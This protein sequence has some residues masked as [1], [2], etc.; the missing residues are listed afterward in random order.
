MVRADDGPATTPERSD[1]DAVVVGGSLAGCATAIFLARAGARVAL[2]EK[3]PDPAA[4]K[5]VCGHFIQSSAVPT[6]ERLGLLPAIEAAGGVRSHYRI[7]TRWGWMPAPREERVPRSLNLRREKL[8][9]LIRA[10]AADTPGVELIA[11][12]T[13][14]DLLGG[15]GRVEG[16]EVSAREGERTRLR[17]PLVVGA[18]GRDSHV[19]RA[20]GVRVRET[21]H[22]RF[23]YGAYYEGPGP[24]GAPDASLWFTDPHWAAAFPT[25]DGLT[26][27][28]CMPTADRL[29]EFRRDP[30]AALEAFV[31]DLPGAPPIR[32]ARRVSPII[33]KVKMPNLQR[34][35]TAP[36]LALVGDAALATDPLWGVGC[37][38]AFQTA[39][40]LADSVAPA[41]R[42]EEP[43]ARGLARYRARHRRG[44]GAHAFMIHDYAT[45]RRFNP[46]E[47]LLFSSAARDERMAEHMTA[48]GSRREQ[49]SFLSRPAV[50]GRALAVNARHRIARRERFALRSATEPA[51]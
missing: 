43:L 23:S 27:Y 38:W 46:V 16:V 35:P 40:W 1:H 9:P 28:G 25:D 51:A 26:M 45:G 29:P 17:A 12:R 2:V 14:G 47:R 42:G 20:A 39:E 6:I 24:E 49:P 36:G 10:A 37:G 7:W 41:L 31:A 4:F 15:D 3:R 21:P 32:G 33:G 18:D 48:Y 19:A 11:G 8:D 50:V 5:R 13:A 34:T 44:L 30:A 22:G